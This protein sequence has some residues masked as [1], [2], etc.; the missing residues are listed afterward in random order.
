MCISVSLRPCSLQ[1]EFQDSQDWYTEKPYLKKPNQPNNQTTSFFIC[2]CVLPASVSEEQ[3]PA[4]CPQWLEA[5]IGSSGIAATYGCEP[6]C[7]CW[8]ANLGLLQEKQVPLT[9][10]PSL[11]PLILF[12]F[13]FEQSPR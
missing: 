13:I 10:E 4:Q 1:R 8:E 9:T 7:P 11:H 2:M 6:P 3:A 12:N 5:G